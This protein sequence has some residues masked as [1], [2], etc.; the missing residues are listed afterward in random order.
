MRQIIS[1]N[2]SWRY[3]EAF[4]DKFINENFDDRQFQ[5][6]HLPHTNK[7]VPRLYDAESVWRAKGSPMHLQQNS[8]LGKLF[9]KSTVFI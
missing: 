5:V 8:A 9:S 6:V 1:L 4:D 2:K 3:S 7:D